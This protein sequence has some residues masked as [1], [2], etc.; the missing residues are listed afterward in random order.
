MAGIRITDLPLQNT[1]NATDVFLKANGTS[2]YGITGAAFINALSGYQTSNTNG[3]GFQILNKSQSTTSNLIFNNINVE[4]P[5]STTNPLSARYAPSGE[6]SISLIKNAI[7]GDFIATGAVGTGQIADNSILATDIGYS[8]SVLNV[9]YN[10]SSSV[11]SSN[12]ASWTDGK[13]NVTI[14]PTRNNSNFLIRCNVM[15]G[16]KTSL[17]SIQR[18]IGGI[19]TILNNN[20]WS[21]V[22][23]GG[24]IP[25]EILDSPQTTSEVSYSL[26]FKTTNTSNNAYVGT[27]STNNNSLLAPI[28][29]S[30]MEI[31]G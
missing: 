23:D 27:N 16:G 20:G 5:Q 4:T 21:S 2:S 24:I 6:V 3:N 10:S 9:Q 28:T 17:V 15:V 12:T 18:S 19:I 8:G 25:I 26:V 29:M 7:T 13:C 14:T 30:V 11:A 22:V 31:H 1:L